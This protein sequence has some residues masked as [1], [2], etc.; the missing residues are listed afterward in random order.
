MDNEFYRAAALN[1]M[2]LDNGDVVIHIFSE[3]A[4]EF[5]DIERL[6]GDGR[7]IMESS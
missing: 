6:W 7:V 5:Y 2:D 3:E 1:Q 4:R